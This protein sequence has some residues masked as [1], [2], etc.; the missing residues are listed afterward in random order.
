MINIKLKQL[1]KKRFCSLFVF[2]FL[3][4]PTVLIGQIRIKAKEKA[5]NILLQDLSETY[6][7]AFSIDAKLAEN[8]Y[9]TLDTVFDHPQKALAALLKECD[10]TYNKSTGVFLIS[11][12]GKPKRDIRSKQHTYIFQLLDKD[13][14]E[15][16][17]N[18]SIWIE[19]K[20]VNA[21]K[22]GMLSLQSKKTILHLQAAHIGYESKDTLV[23]PKGL[24]KLY[25]SPRK[26]YLEEVVLEQ[27]S[28][29]QKKEM[30][31]KAGLIK[32]NH[33]VV[34]FL[35]GNNNNT[36]YNLLYLQPGILGAAENSSD[37]SI[38][39]S[40]HGQNLIQFDQIPLFSSSALNN[41]LGIVNGLMIND[42]TV[43]KGG[44]GVTQ[45]DRIGGIIDLTGKMGNPQNFSTEVNLNTQY[46]SG[47]V[48]VPLP[49]QVVFQ[50]SFRS[51]LEHLLGDQGLFSSGFNKIDWFYIP[52]YTFK[53]FNI[54]LSRRSSKSDQ[55]YISFLGNKERSFYKFENSVLNP[56]E[57]WESN[58]N[59]Q[60]WGGSLFYTK[61]WQNL[62]IL[63]AALSYTDYKVDL[64]SGIEPLD[65][66]GDELIPLDSISLSTKGIAKAKQ[67]SENALLEED[68]FI[69]S[70][71]GI[72]TF[73]AKI[74]HQW[75][76][77]S[78]HNIK[79]GL[80]FTNNGTYYKQ[81]TGLGDLYQ[82][83]NFR[84]IGQW[85]AYLQDKI[86]LSSQSSLEPGIKINYVPY[87]N[88]LF[89]QPRFRANLNWNKHWQ[90]NLAWG[91]YN[92]FLTEIIET[93]TF[94]NY[95]YFWEIFDNQTF[96]VS[97]SQHFLVKVQFDK[98][99]W[100]GFIEAYVK[101]TNGIFRSAAES[102]F[103]DAFALSYGKGKGR[104]IDFKIQRHHSKLDFWVA[105]SYSRMLE[106]FDHNSYQRAPHD[107]THELKGA[108]IINQNPWFF[109]LNGI[110]GSGLY[111]NNLGKNPYKRIDIAFR[112]DFRFVHGQFSTG[113]SITNLLNA[114]NIGALGRSNL[115][116]DITIYSRGLPRTPR[117]F[118]KCSF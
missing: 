38:W 111:L 103:S 109:S 13:N 78:F 72:R 27:D 40:Y 19:N 117:L 28:L 29:T 96:L 8:C 6:G 80:A 100:Q 92:Q 7:L 114:K 97:N 106:N 47:R 71:N 98:N 16:L 9:L 73:T 85:K 61:A 86:Y 14:E 53:D 118:L 62:G 76:T 39:G 99:K 33:H 67:S 10:L 82:L 112:Y 32:L 20:L 94:G 57:K 30:T 70:T 115:P 52:N 60:Q 22:N 24:L 83:P 54:K 55:F 21:N 41:Q 18:A 59:R 45:E 56:N 102:L 90:L 75:P 68:F 17:P 48:N 12:K 49:Q 101:K 87:S 31:Q 25:L 79:W 63:S 110:Y 66:S 108:M 51:S 23:V 44:F 105:Y 84:Q 35:L 65:L 77:F 81:G 5:L 64:S 104:G 69:Q 91:Y 26:F 89:W 34:A 74:D 50:G 46:L 93:D 36:L 95:Y 113:L 4:S 107:Q 37:F 11:K 3:F 42:V 43:Y 15:P 88:Q 116:N 1:N 58:V 2:L